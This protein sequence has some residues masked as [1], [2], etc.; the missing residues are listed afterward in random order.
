[1]LTWEYSPRGK[2]GQGCGG[3]PRRLGNG[4]G[5]LT[6]RG[7]RESQA[8]KKPIQIYAGCAQYVELLPDGGAGAGG[9]QGGDGGG[10]GGIVVPTPGGDRCSADVAAGLHRFALCS[11]SALSTTRLIDGSDGAALGVDGNFSD[12]K[13]V[14]LAGAL[15]ASGQVRL[16]DGGQTG[17]SLRAGGGLLAGNPVHVLGDTFSGG[18]VTGPLTIDGTLHAPAAATVD[19]SVAAQATVREAVSVPDPCDCN[20]AAAIDVAGAISAAAARNDDAAIGLG[21]GT[22]SASVTLPA[23]RYYV[24]ALASG[25]DVP[26][27]VIT[28]RGR[29]ALYVAGDVTLKGALTV[30]FDPGAELDLFVGGGL[31]TDSNR[32][33]GAPDAPARLRIWLGGGT[34]ALSG[35][36][37][38]GAVITAAH[39]PA[40]ADNGLIVY[41]SLLAAGFSTDNDA[42]FH[43]DSA[44]LSAGTACGGSAVAPVP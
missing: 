9:G 23:G 37:T 30:T 8:K 4:S 33:F 25:S 27:V 42:S 35:R 2:L 15:Y 7:L 21:S 17:A 22:L 13:A 14:T 31:S 29:V 5:G 43:Y 18:D 44:I 32:S 20:A 38:V 41:G 28:V 34:L 16:G 10:S 24:A 11:C 1:L 19:G 26:D 40:V 6:K 39:A 3:E 36:P 12:D